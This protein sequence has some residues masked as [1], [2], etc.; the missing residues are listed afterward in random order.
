MNVIKSDRNWTGYTCTESKDTTQK[1]KEVRNRP[2]MET[3][4]TSREYKRGGVR[5][6]AK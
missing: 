3:V 5:P 2:K 4:V 1:S 6:A